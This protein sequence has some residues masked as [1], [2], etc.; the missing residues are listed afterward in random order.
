LPGLSRSLAETALQ[1]THAVVLL[2]TLA[3]TIEK[4]AMT[5]DLKFMRATPVS[6]FMV[7]FAALMT[8]ILGAWVLKVRRSSTGL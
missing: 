5:M 4:M 8:P 6:L 2:T 3:V 7:S 1:P